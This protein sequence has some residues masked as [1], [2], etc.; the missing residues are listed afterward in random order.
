MQD[1]IYNLLKNEKNGKIIKIILIFHLPNFE[2]PNFFH[3]WTRS[4]TSSTTKFARWRRITRKSVRDDEGK[5]PKS[6][7]EGQWGSP[8]REL[9]KK[10]ELRRIDKIW[11]TF[12]R[13]HIL[14]RGGPKFDKFIGEVGGGS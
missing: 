9:T 13:C 8:G 1:R 11:L 2:T 12:R 5:I 14:G 4:T 6:F 3:F 7:E 10:L